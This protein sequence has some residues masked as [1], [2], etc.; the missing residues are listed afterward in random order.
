MLIVNL[1]VASWLND[2]ILCE[3]ILSKFDQL[4]SMFLGLIWVETL[5]CE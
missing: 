4:A 1:A 5:L 3:H 2:L